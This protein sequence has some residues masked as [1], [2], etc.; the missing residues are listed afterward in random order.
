MLIEEAMYIFSD[1]PTDTKQQARKSAR[2][3]KLS[4]YGPRPVRRRWPTWEAQHGGGTR[5]TGHVRTD[6]WR[7]L[8]VE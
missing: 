7:L 8:F 2:E 1:R 6:F 5:A 4:V 3:H